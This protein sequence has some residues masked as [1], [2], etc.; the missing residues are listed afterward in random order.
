MG[1]V[2]FKDVDNYLSVKTAELNAALAVESVGGLDDLST[3][4]QRFGQLPGG[5]S[6]TGPGSGANPATNLGYRGRTTGNRQAISTNYAVQQS[7]EYFRN[8]IGGLDEGQQKAILNASF[9]E[10]GPA[11]GAGGTA[12]KVS[13]AEK[14]DETRTMLS[15]NIKAL[16]SPASA[17]YG[18]SS[19][20]G[21]KIREGAKTM[22]V[23]FRKA[24]LEALGAE[25]EN[26]AK[27]GKGK[28]GVDLRTAN[29]ELAQMMMGLL[30][31][32]LPGMA[33]D[34]TGPG[35]MAGGGQN[36]IGSQLAAGGG[37]GPV[38]TK[39]MVSAAARAAREGY[40][41]A[42]LDSRYGAL[43]KTGKRKRFFAGRAVDR[44]N[45]GRMAGITMAGDSRLTEQGRLQKEAAGDK[46]RQTKQLL[47][48]K[49][50]DKFTQAELKLRGD[51]VG[52]IEGIT[53]SF[54]DQITEMDRLQ[55]QYAEV[56]DKELNQRL[57]TLDAKQMVDKDLTDAEI[58]EV[59]YLEGL[60]KLR[61]ANSRETTHGI[62][63]INKSRKSEKENIDK[64][65]AA[66]IS[67]RKAMLE[68]Q[69]AVRVQAITDAEVKTRNEAAG[70]RGLQDDGY[71]ITNREIADADKNAR[72]ARIR[73][74]GAGDSGAAFRE[75]FAY[76]DTDALLEFEDGVVDV[77]NTM[78]S[79]FASAFQ[80]ISSGATT[81]GGAI[82]GMAQNILNSISQASSQMFT[83]MLFSRMSGQFSQGGLV[84]GYAS[85]G[86]VTGGSGNK[87][88]VLTKMQGGEFVIKKS[89]AQ[90]IGYGTLN[91]INSYAGGGGVPQDN[92]NAAMG[93]MGAIAAGAGAVS[94][95]IGAAMQDKP[96]APLPMQDYG[97]GRGQYG[98]FGGAD[99]DAGQVDSISGGR[100][101][102][103]VSLGKSFSYYRRDPDSGELI[104]ERARPTEGRF[105]VS[106]RL[107]L[108]GRL[109][110][111]PQTRRM[112]GKE[113][114]MA[115]YQQYLAD[116]TKSR[117]DQIQAV[118]DQ[119]K[120]RRIQA[121]VNAVM[122]IGGAYAMDKMQAAKMAKVG[123]ADPAG[124][125]GYG[126]SAATTSAGAYDGAKPHFGQ[127]AGAI[128]TGANIGV[129]QLLRNPPVTSTNQM[130]LLDSHQG[131]PSIRNNMRQGGASGS[132][133][134]LG[135]G[136][137]GF[138][139]DWNAAG[140][141]GGGGG[142]NGG[143]ARVMGG[144]YVMSPEAVRTY[145]TDFMT[146]LNRG[147]A[148][149]FANGG[150]VGF[151]NGGPVGG[152]TVGGGG[153]IGTTNNVRINVNIDKRGAPEASA[154][155]KSE[156]PTAQ[157]QQAED[158]N[159][160]LNNKEFAG[161]LEGVVLEQIVKQQRP[162][163]LLSPNTP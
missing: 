138:K 148:P 92:S 72:R 22:A 124:W 151:S 80:S 89:S 30:S 118:E 81:V 162:G 45:A 160:V 85:G 7:A 140:I 139:P 1:G 149:G 5:Y 48:I 109:G 107:S 42:G 29:V 16:Q 38:T 53:M 25:L 9:F 121:G 110:G 142:A 55:T 101:R 105:E 82:A 14:I 133:G 153:G 63:E 83:N 41:T 146:E 157:G 70:L 60:R 87:D 75:A 26:E 49:Q 113:Q 76:G 67:E 95:M 36:M 132:F 136:K 90:Q 102:A 54:N 17:G 47:R 120:A 98:Y 78:K 64:S 44:A 104:S 154:D 117:A 129:P 126:A 18:K 11:G 74:G 20:A 119:K 8:R 28:T 61:E 159:E 108:L 163:G 106:S 79:S 147:N 111:D 40:T 123:G 52:S 99:P 15:E 68:F 39:G 144:E 77:A 96:P 152:A 115:S 6:Y 12:R 145:G 128:E 65:T 46:A 57:K 24:G 93:K 122:M 23:L 32:G 97:K 137:Y 84:P 27:K 69:R 112:F 143:L 114:K 51:L 58:A 100:G 56:S 131:S 161:V 43:G 125:E 158:N 35:I 141:G 19:I 94:G 156:D 71:G 31:V 3:K 135:D 103:Q 59:K 88:D 4:M 73:A 127:Y 50:L 34:P 116:E 86:V 62:S 66:R 13:G 91:A 134:S 33:Y 37:G 21:G 10:G 130:N 2:D 155:S 150:P